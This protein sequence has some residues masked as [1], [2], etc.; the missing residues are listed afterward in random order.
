MA[1]LRAASAQAVPIY[2]RFVRWVLD[3]DEL[4]VLVECD[5][6][7]CLEQS[8][9]L[10]GLDLGVN[11][12]SLHVTIGSVRGIDPLQHSAFLAAVEAAFPIANESLFLCT[13][14]GYGAVHLIKGRKGIQMRGLRTNRRLDTSSA[15]QIANVTPKHVKQGRSSKA[16]TTSV[17]S[18]TRATLASGAC[19]SSSAMEVDRGPAHAPTIRKP[20][21]RLSNR[22]S[23]NQSGTVG[24]RRSVSTLASMTGAK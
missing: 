2:G 11:P 14:L 8:L 1:A 15:P 10:Q 22:R 17:N 21:R 23:P 13:Q 12:Q 4:R 6:L 18:S 16:S 9:R 20:R 3:S 7:G 19:G 24:Y 5:E